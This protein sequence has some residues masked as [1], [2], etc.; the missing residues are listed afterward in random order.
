[1]EERNYKAYGINSF[2]RDTQFQ[3]D[4]ELERK[5]MGIAVRNLCR[6]NK[7]DENSAEARKR[8]QSQIEDAGLGRALVSVHSLCALAKARQPTNS[9]PLVLTAIR[10]DYPLQSDCRCFYDHHRFTTVPVFLP[11]A[12]HSAERELVSIL[13]SF[14]FCSFSC[15]RSWI[16]EKA[17]SGFRGDNMEIMLA[18]FARKFFGITESIKYAPS[19]LLHVDYGGLLNT[20]QW[21]ALCTTHHSILR[22]P[23][24]IAAPSTIVS[25]VYVRSR[26]DAGKVARI[27]KR[28]EETHFN[29]V[30]ER[31]ERNSPDAAEAAKRKLKEGA[32]RP[33]KERQ[34]V[35]ADGNRVVLSDEMLNQRIMQSAAQRATKPKSSSNS[36][37]QT[38]APTAK[39]FTVPK[40]AAKK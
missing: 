27:S 6:A 33:V 32:G 18:I 38:V 23:T 22:Q 1:M 9:Q 8:A 40:R 20:K 15:A 7:D 25:E 3:E 19:V 4:V 37:K 35:D 36:M 14:C 13:T 2:F 30:P 26:K 12:F 24:C 10:D 31:P 28:T 29:A 5:L 17:P 39:V 34:T 16:R 11:L 21:R